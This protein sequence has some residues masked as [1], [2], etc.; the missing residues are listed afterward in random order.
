VVD[1]TDFNLLMVTT[2]IKKNFDIVPEEAVN[3]QIA[4]D[5]YKEGLDKKC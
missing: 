1:D 4:V 3:G 5:K 2:L